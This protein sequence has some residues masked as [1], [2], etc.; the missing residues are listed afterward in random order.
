LIVAPMPQFNIIDTNVTIAAGAT[1]L[2]KTTSS[3]DVISW[4]WSPPTDLSCTN[5]SQPVAKGNKIIQYT[6]IAANAY[7]CSVSDKILI[8]G[9][10]NS[11]VIFIPNTFSPNGD[12]VNDYFYPRGSGLYLIKSMRIF[13]RIG[14]LVYEKNNF[15]PDVE[16]EGWNGT[17]HSKKLPS[18][19][20]VYFI[21][22]MCNNG[23]V[24][25]FKGDI[26]LL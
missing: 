14:Q 25:S 18:D 11:Q 10:C 8:K 1:Y 21:E 5:C 16:T 23:V 22:V 3:P 2:I 7:G 4:Q 20:Y 19:V 26:T 15:A 12:H 6:G 17:F 9:L 13:N 24:V